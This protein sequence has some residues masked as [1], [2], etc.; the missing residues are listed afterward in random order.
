[1]NEHEIEIRAERMQDRLD[2]EFSTTDMSDMQYETRCEIIRAW[3]NEQYEKL[4]H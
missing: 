3:V 2:R 1:M 4:K